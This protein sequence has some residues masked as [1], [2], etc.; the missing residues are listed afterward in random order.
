MNTRTTIEFVGVS[1]L[2][3]LL[4]CS[5]P[6]PVA[7]VVAAQPEWQTVPEPEVSIDLPLEQEL[8]PTPFGRVCKLGTTC[9]A[10]DPRPFEPCLLSTKN[11][12]DKATEP[13][14][15][16]QPQQ[17]DPPVIIKTNR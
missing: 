15:T 1:A 13:L 12:S 5:T 3:L 17:T 9:L 14:L 4:G 10:M 11:C 8:T 16:G 6:Q 2:A 7:P